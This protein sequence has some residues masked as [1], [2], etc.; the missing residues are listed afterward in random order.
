MIYKIKNKSKLISQIKRGILMSIIAFIIGAMIGDISNQKKDIKE[1]KAINYQIKRQKDSIQS[2]VWDL[3][4][5]NEVLEDQHQNLLEERKK[6]ILFKMDWI[7]DHIEMGNSTNNN[8]MMNMSTI[9]I[10][11]PTDSIMCN[12]NVIWA[13]DTTE[14]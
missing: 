4:W 12:N 1:L 11:L 3:Q 13:T 14:D 6:D 7:I 8:H 5:E 10:E 2:L 9:T